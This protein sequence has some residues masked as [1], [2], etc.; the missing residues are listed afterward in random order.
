[1][2]ISFF[3]KKIRQGISVNEQLAK[4]FHKPVTKKLKRR[5]VYAR[6]KDNIWSADLAEMGSLF[7]KNKNAKYLLYVIDVFP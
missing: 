1:M 3:D 7:F 6:F 2:S 4:Q 5:K